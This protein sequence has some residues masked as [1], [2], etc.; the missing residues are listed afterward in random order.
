MPA[1]CGTTTNSHVRVP[2]MPVGNVC[3]SLF[4]CGGYT[5][6]P[7]TTNSGARSIHLRLPL[8]STRKRN[9]TASPSARIGLSTAALALNLPTAPLNPGSS[10]MGLTSSVIDRK[11]VV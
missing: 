11:S 3:R 2:E 4:T 7:G 9:V 5:L 6:A 1:V 10:G 8:P